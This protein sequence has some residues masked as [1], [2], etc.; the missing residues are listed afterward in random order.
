MHE[1]G[2]TLRAFVSKY[3]LYSSRFS[4]RVP[5]CFINE[6]Y[7]FVQ[8]FYKFILVIEHQNRE[9]ISAFTVDEHIL[10]HDHDSLIN[11]V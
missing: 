5:F 11:N 3:N 10:E 2:K 9:A 7:I 1:D 6:T 4:Y 8:S